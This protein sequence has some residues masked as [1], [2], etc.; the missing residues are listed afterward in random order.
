MISARY[1]LH[2]DAADQKSYCTG[3]EKPWSRPFHSKVNCDPGAV[4]SAA[5]AVRR[6]AAGETVLFA[7]RVH[8]ASKLS[9]RKPTEAMLR[10]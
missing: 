2:S 4:A 9:P 10:P 6:R 1:A 3:R 7:C 8:P 5:V